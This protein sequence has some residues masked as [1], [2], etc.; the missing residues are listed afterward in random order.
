MEAG[1][2]EKLE[3]DEQAAYWLRV[4]QNPGPDERAA[5]WSWLRA[6]PA[7]MRELLLAGKLDHEFE[8]F[9]RARRI[10]VEALIAKSSSKILQSADGIGWDEPPAEKRRL[11]PG[12]LTLAAASTVLFVAAAFLTHFITDVRG[13]YV[14]KLGEQRLLDLEDGSV[15]ILNTQSKVK[16]SY[17][18][19][20]R[21]IYLD[22]GQAL[23]R[24]RHDAARPFRV[25]TGTAVIQA[26]GT[27]FDVRVFADR[28]TVAVVEG[29][30]QVLAPDEVV[31]SSAVDWAAFPAPSRIT[32]GEGAIIDAGGKIEQPTKI[33]TGTAVA[34]TQQRLVFKGET[35]NHIANEF[36]RY[37]VTPRLR[38][39]DK[40]LSEK[41]F[42][43][44]FNAHSPAALLDYLAEDPSVV[45]DRDGDEIVIRSRSDG[46]PA[47]V[48]Q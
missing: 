30:V 37:N 36:N 12:W 44:V 26:V 48:H 1:R 47:Q 13:T 3:V 18:A 23:F 5:F 39:E 27:Q 29:T 24:V 42:I 22:D 45:F 16:V 7:H 25:H 14:T 17:T 15:I 33:D 46:A 9:D 35:L 28:T 4:M 21:D 2:L 6:S 43:G 38:I 11:R 20:A 19:Q 40:A 8:T 34:W 10:D 41:R 31:A 32:A